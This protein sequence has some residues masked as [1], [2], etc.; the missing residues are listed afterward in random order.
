MRI[1][2]KKSPDA[3]HAPLAR[4]HLFVR[5][6]DLTAS[7][8]GSTAYAIFRHAMLNTILQSLRGAKAR[9]LICAACMLLY[10]P[11]AATGSV[12]SSDFAAVV[13]QAGQGTVGILTQATSSTAFTGKFSVRGSG[14]YLGDG[15]ILT[16]RHATTQHAGRHEGGNTI[17]PPRIT[18]I[19]SALEEA[20]ATLVGVNHFLDLAL[21]RI[22]HELIPRGLS[23]RR[24]AQTEALPGERVFTV[25]YPLGWGPAVSYGYVGNPRTFLKTVESRLVQVDL[26]ACSGNSGGGLFNAQGDIA[27]IVHAIIQTD[28]NRSTSGER[29][30]SRFAFAVPGPLA[31]K[32]VTAL[33]RGTPFHFSTLGLRLASVKIDNQ[34]RVA[35][36]NATGPAQRAGIRTGDVLLS[37]DEQPVDSAGQLKNYVMEHTRPF[38]PVTMRILRDDREQMIKVITGKAHDTR[39]A[40]PLRRSGT[41]PQKP[42]TE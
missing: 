34:W 4:R 20:A 7:G 11:M 32:I 36:A 22:A 31:H 17:D 12:N 25:G 39:Q 23:A 42:S 1:Q 27:G 2:D 16:A 38:Q 15:Y 33:M 18:V 26:S 8:H 19:S 6:P 21:Y 30:C 29:R 14:L 40:R 3:T 35:V 5:G 24:F 41:P 9:R 37:I 10:S 13:R 28:T